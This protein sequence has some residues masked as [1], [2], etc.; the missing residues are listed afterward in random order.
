MKTRLFEKV[1]ALLQLNRNT[2]YH[3]L[4]FGCGRGEY[5]ELLSQ[6]V[7]KRSRLVGY[8]PMEKALAIAGANCPTAEFIR[9]R[10]VHLFPFPDASFDLVVTIDTIEC[11][12]RKDALIDE[13][14]RILKPGGQI[15]ASHWDWDTQIYNIPNLELARKAV[16]AFSDWKQPWMDEADGQMGRKL[17]GLFEGSGTFHGSPDSFCLIETEYTTGE[18]GFDRAQDLSVLV[19]TGGF[20]RGE[21]EQFC[22]ELVESNRRGHYL[23]RLTAFMYHGRRV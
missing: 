13:I 20:D 23:Y 16:R 19:E 7:G 6:S 14:H 3:V 9:E 10:F 12:Q 22:Q 5:L 17:W 2:D 8:D 11:L 15:L 18:Y 4:D 1:L 21:Y